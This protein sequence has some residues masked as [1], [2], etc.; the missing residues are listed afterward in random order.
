[1]VVREAQQGYGASIPWSPIEPLDMDS[2]DMG[3]R[4]INGLHRQWLEVRASVEESTP[5]AYDQFNEELFRS[6]AIETGIIEGLYDLDRGVTLTLIQ[7]G[8]S[9]DI[10]DELSSN[11]PPNDLVA[12]LRAHRDSIDYVNG[13]IEESRPLTKF[14]IRSLHQAITSTQTTYQAIN[15]L[16]QWFD[17]EL[18]RGEFKRLPNNPTRLTGLFISTVLLSRSRAS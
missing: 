10:I 11:V 8:F 17:A 1:M 9:G 7:Q 6:W 18:H 12:T 15:T 16:G 13:W 5:K 14:F 3:F 2:I 4:E